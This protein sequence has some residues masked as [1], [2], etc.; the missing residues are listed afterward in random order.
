MKRGDKYVY[1]LCLFMAVWLVA[2]QKKAETS[3]GGG[4][5][6]VVLP[7]KVY[8]AVSLLL[9]HYD[10][11]DMSYMIYDF[12]DFSDRRILD[13]LFDGTIR[14]RD[15]WVPKVDVYTLACQIIH[16]RYHYYNYYNH[17]SPGEFGPDPSQEGADA[18][19]RECKR[20]I[21]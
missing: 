12:H 13:V 5:P 4:E 19:G 17:E 18:A 3:S 10:M 7:D 11:S 14:I 20:L 8:H 15:T 1:T 16:E 21:T 6:D 2:C 9:P